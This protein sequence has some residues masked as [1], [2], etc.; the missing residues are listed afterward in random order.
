MLR[1]RRIFHRTVLQRFFFSKGIIPIQSLV[2]AEV[3]S[4]LVSIVGKCGGAAQETLNEILV[5]M[6]VDRKGEL[7]FGEFLLAMRK[8]M[9]ENW[10]NV[11]PQA[12]KVA[13]KTAEQA[14]AMFAGTSGKPERRTITPGWLRAD[15]PQYRGRLEKQLQ[16]G[17]T[18]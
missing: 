18:A 16:S 7:L 3:Q 9:D 10:H 13:D 5:S 4:M 6:D 11:N 14:A 17:D 15:L 1:F 12:Q 2:Y 8:V